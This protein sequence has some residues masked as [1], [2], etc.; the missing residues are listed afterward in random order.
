VSPFHR[1]KIQT[2][3]AAAGGPPD[4]A[5]AAAGRSRFAFRNH[6]NGV[7]H[8]TTDVRNI[9]QAALNPSLPAQTV[10]INADRGAR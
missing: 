7:F 3:T 5:D 10:F 2:P 4:L 1:G 9:D 8:V 6:E